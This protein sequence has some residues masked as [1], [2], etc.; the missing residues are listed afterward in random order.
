MVGDLKLTYVYPEYTR[1][2]QRVIPNSDGN[3][4]AIAGTE[5]RF[6][7]RAIVKAARAELVKGNKEKIVLK[8]GPR[9]RSVSGKLTL[10]K[11]GTYRF[12]LFDAHTGQKAARESRSTYLLQIF[13]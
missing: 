11:P 12:R 7:A 8:L 5:V 9:G 1:L 2:G 6:Q 13:R 10:L 3:L 4:S